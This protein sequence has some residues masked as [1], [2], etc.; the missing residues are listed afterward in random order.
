MVQQRCII[1]DTQK[2]DKDAA[3]PSLTLVADEI[4]DMAVGDV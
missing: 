2:L 4:D 3:L 1:I